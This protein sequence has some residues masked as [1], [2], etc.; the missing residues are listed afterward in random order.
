MVAFCEARG[1]AREKPMPEFAPVM[2]AVSL[3]RSTLGILRVGKRRPVRMAVRER[4]PF[5]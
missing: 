2:R 5:K 4:R 3:V 1:R